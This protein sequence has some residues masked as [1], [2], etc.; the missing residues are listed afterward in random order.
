MVS[1]TRLTVDYREAPLAVSAPHPGFSWQL[2]SPRRGCCQKAYQILVKQGSKVLWDTGR[3]ASDN[4]LNILYEGLAL[5]PETRYLWQVTVWDELDESST[6]E[7]FFE[8]VPVGWHG[9]KW[10]GSDELILSAHTQSVFQFSYKDVF[11]VGNIVANVILKT[12]QS[13]LFSNQ[14]RYRRNG[15]C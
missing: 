6:A 8:T 13:L 12:K 7:S 14:R 4:T 10:I 15:L 2:I 3:I 5:N 9:A 1:V 11:K